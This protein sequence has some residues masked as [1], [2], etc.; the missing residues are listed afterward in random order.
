MNQDTLCM[1]CFADTG[2]GFKPCSVCGY[3]P[4]YNPEESIYLAPR[5]ILANKY[6]VG[7]VLGQGGFGITYLGWDLNLETRLAIKEYFPQGHVSR[8]PGQSKVISLA[9]TEA[10]Q[11]D[12]W[13]NRFVQE[14]KTLAQ[15]ESHPNIV[16]VRDFFEANNTAYMIMNYIE[17]LTLEQYLS[18]CGGSISFSTA[19]DVVIPVLD[20]L[21]AVHQIGFMHRDISPGNICIDND[22]RVVVIDFG[23][24]R[25]EMR[26]KSKSLSV[27]LKAGYA[28]IEQYQSRG[29]QGPWTDIYAVGATMYRAITGQVPLDAIDRLSDDDLKPPS[30]LDVQIDPA[31]EQ[32]LLKAMAVKI[33]DRYQSVEDFMA[34]LRPNE[35][36]DAHH[37]ENLSLFDGTVPVLGSE[38]FED[39]QNSADSL[40]DV[41]PY[42]AYSDEEYRLEKEKR[43]G[44]KES[45]SKIKY[46]AALVVGVV[47]LVSG[48]ALFGSGTE[49]ETANQDGVFN[50]GDSVGAGQTVD[51]EIT[52]QTIDTS[53]IAGLDADY[54]I[55]Y[56][57]GTIPL[58]NLQIGS[59]VVDPS[60]EWEYRIGANY[61]GTGQ[62]KPV[63]W[64]VVARDHYGSDSGVTL[65]SDELIGRVAYDNS[66]HL[67]E[68]GNNHWGE[69]GSHSTATWGLRPWLNS[70]GIH[71]GEGF[72]QA[73][74]EEFKQAIVVTTLPNN[75]GQTG[76]AYYT[77]DRVFIPSTTELGQT[78][79]QRSYPIG[80]IFPYFAESN[81]VNRIA[82]LGGSRSWY[83]TRTPVADRR[84]Y[85][86]NISPDD[87]GFYI[88]H[89]NRNGELGI[90]PALNLKAETMVSEIIK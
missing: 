67:N 21:K 38:K 23:A 53:K 63:I 8:M 35:S 84:Q 55:D 3:I 54:Y 19:L 4:D 25:Q 2:G 70:T 50:M 37:E 79:H 71:S 49:P 64:L 18:Y 26:E 46:T 20:A 24:S 40:D 56:T 31:Q 28:P 1:G 17:G 22:G 10:E 51:L 88:S 12:F 16:S 68:Y 66:T 39:D 87:G 44:L 32:A 33:E 73:F 15:F 27:I 59:R 80:K 41:K 72:S 83:R 61:S 90:R 62:V 5:T 42:Q 76:A 78:V 30:M 7:N 86:S 45:N 52:A 9:G 60:W 69:S 36:D 48:I 81:H 6:L 77:E 82:S 13:L 58:G 29:R 75:D 14:S 47:L 65:L 85:S 11:F 74:S 89:L 34:D 57:G 43:P